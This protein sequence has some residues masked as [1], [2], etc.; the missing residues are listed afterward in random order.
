MTQDILIVDDE[1]DIR[2]L[3]SGILSDEGYGTRVAKDGT[4]ALAAIKFRQPNLVILDVWLGDGERDGIRILEMI[5]RDH[6]YVP[7]IMMSGHGTIETAVCAIK[8]GAYDFIEKPFEAERMLLVINRALEAAKLRRENEELKVKTGGTELLGSS[9]AISHIRQAIDKVAGSNS[10]I[11]IGGP[12]GSGK[13]VIARLIHQQSKRA[14]SPFIHINCSAIHPD[15]IEAELFGTEII[16]L[17][18]SLPRKIGLIERAHGGTLYL[19]EVMDLPLPAQAK[20][21]RVLQEGGFCRLGDNQR[22]EVDVRIIAATSKCVA[23]EIKEGRFRQDLYDRL[24]VIPIEVPPLTERLTDIPELVNHF[25]YQASR[26]HG[27]A[28]RTLA[29][30]ALIMMQSYPWPGNVR[31]LKNV[32]E[33][34]LLMA[35]GDAREP[36]TC[37]MLPPEIR[38]DVKMPS[39][40]NPSIVIM[41]LRE[42]REAFER[43]YLLT[44]VNRFGGNISKT[45][46]FIG[47]ERS[48]LH[49]KL[50]ALGVHEGRS[51]VDEDEL[52]DKDVSIA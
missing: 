10:R 28:V 41:P 51:E 15:H 22:I 27:R 21:I 3:V 50:R 48:A 38:T 1:A 49:R 2:E 33:W 31:Q 42:A 19:N 35:P 18:E 47:M 34:V 26:S 52:Q 17:D 4:E 36:V 23:E 6:P 30:E 37:E 13:E 24:S 44:Q 39:L 45:A 7:V 11:F 25:M 40:G 16:G 20:L 14:N 8:R 46:R 29:P 12:S 43:E 32:V 5:K 9:T